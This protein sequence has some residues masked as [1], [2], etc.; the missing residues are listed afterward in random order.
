MRARRRTADAESKTEVVLIAPRQR[1][2]CSRDSSLGASSLF[3][4]LKM[5]SSPGLSERCGHALV[6]LSTVAH[7]V[8][9][10]LLCLV[11][12]AGGGEGGGGGWAG[13]GRWGGG[14]VWG[15]DDVCCFR[16]QHIQDKHAHRAAVRVWRGR[17]SVVMI[18]RFAVRGAETHRIH[19]KHGVSRR[20]RECTLSA[21]LKHCEYKQT[22]VFNLTY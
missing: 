21:V 20:G 13:D 5:Q 11:C 18:S 8:L 10:L 17:S 15:G 7:R 9:L 3:L 14:E 6:P 12:E 19:R 1:P 22:R 16:V 4:F 2:S